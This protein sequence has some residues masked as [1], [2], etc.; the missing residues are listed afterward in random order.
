MVQLTNSVITNFLSYVLYKPS[1]K[2]FVKRK[3]DEVGLS[4]ITT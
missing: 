4:E 2:D 3:E 1:L